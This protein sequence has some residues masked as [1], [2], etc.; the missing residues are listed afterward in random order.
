MN[1]PIHLEL[2]LRIQTL[3]GFIQIEKLSILIGFVS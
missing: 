1:P 3:N 2:Q